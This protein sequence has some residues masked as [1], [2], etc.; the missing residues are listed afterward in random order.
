MSVKASKTSLVRELF[1]RTADE[2]YITARWCAVNGLRTDF[3][4]LA[5]HALE[6]YLKAV[7]LE[8]GHSGK[9]DSSGKMYGHEIDRLYADVKAIAGSLLPD[10][11]KKPANLDV[12]HWSERSADEFVEH[13]LQNGNADNRYLI[14]GYV[15]RSQDLHML[16]QIVFAVR[17]LICPL[18]EPIVSADGKQ[19]PTHRKALTDNP[20]YYGRLFMPLDNLIASEEDIPNRRTALNENHAFAPEGF[21]HTPL[22]EGSSALNPVI[23][24]RIID[25]LESDDPSQAAEG[26]D[27]ANWFLANVKVPKG[28]PNDPGVEEQ[29]KDAIAAA[30]KKHGLP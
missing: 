30:R 26:I 10:R 27:V 6:K 5:V 17:R 16:D 21:Q 8:N 29:I 9:S 2:N 11:L 7:L 3:F 25:P 23:L 12:C 13:L 14:Y 20:Q 28:K 15:M 19:M 24:R 4:W 1:V 22:P 18:D